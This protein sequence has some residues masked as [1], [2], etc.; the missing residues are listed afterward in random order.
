MAAPQRKPQADIYTVLLVIAF[1]AI[2][3]AIIFLYLETADYGTYKYNGAPPVAKVDA[4][5]AATRLANTE[6]GKPTTDVA[7]LLSSVFPYSGP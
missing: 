5:D 6:S 4:R 7:F 3:T 1:V 2:I